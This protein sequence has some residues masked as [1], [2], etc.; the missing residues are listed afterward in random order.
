MT[1][2]PDDATA[3][4]PDDPPIR[5]AFIGAGMMGRAHTHAARAAGA[6][7]VSVVA[8][9]PERAAAAAAELGVES[10][11][12]DV[13]GALAA[14]P[15]VVHVLSPNSLHVPQAREVIAAGRHV[16]CEKP[17]ATSAD[18]ARSLLRAAE[19]AGVS[20]AVPFVYRY[21]PMIRE[22][23][24]RIAAGGEDVL[25]IDARYLQDWLIEKDDDNWRATGDGGPSRAFADIGSHLFDAIEFVSGRRVAAVN[26]VTSRVY[27]TRAGREISNEDIAAVLFRLEGGAPG[28]ALVSQ[29]AAGHKN[30]LELE[31]HTTS[32]A[33]RFEQERPGTLRIGRRG[34]TEILEQDP[35]ALAPDA[36]RL[37]HVP[38]G[39]PTGYQ[40]AFNAFVRDAYAAIRGERP[41]GLPTFADGVRAAQVTD[42]VLASAASGGWV[43]TPSEN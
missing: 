30:G 33:Y 42:A 15:D 8:S 4:T 35:A 16:I 1:P 7:L 32:E 9:R 5:A 34:S 29:V 24:A 17:L 40:D 12:A 41:E 25:S 21:H 19:A 37:A 31:V 43:E 10:G 28:V 3:T 2:T 20:H 26:A 11:S 14:D 39:H 6:R 36:A 22:A 23:R 38:A 18:D 13:A 27:A